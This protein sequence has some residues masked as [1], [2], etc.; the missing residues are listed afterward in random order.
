MRNHRAFAGI[1]QREH[2]NPRYRQKRCPDRGALVFCFER[3]SN[4]RR[5]EPRAKHHGPG[6]SQGFLPPASV[7]AWASVAVVSCNGNFADEPWANH[8]RAKKGIAGV[9]ALRA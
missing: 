7:A 8:R 5:T 1:S 3:I 6:A 2:R 9:L 4:Y